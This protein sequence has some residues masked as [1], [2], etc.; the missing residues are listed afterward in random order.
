MQIQVVHIKPT[1]QIPVL[2]SRIVSING[3]QSAWVYN[4]NPKSNKQKLFGG[5]FSLER[6]EAMRGDY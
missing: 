2:V 3:K 5:D 1:T 4:A 6:E